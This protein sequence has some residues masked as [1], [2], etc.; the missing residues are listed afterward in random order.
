M[1]KAAK[2]TPK[3]KT[4]PKEKQEEQGYTPDDVA[5]AER[6]LHAVTEALPQI[7]NILKTT[8]EWS[9]DLKTK[10]PLLRT[11]Y[12]YRDAVDPETFKQF[13]TL[14]D[15]LRMAV[16]GVDCDCDPAIRFD[17]LDRSREEDFL[18]ACRVPRVGDDASIAKRFQQLELARINLKC[19]QST[20]ERMEKN[21]EADLKEII[22]KDDRRQKAKDCETCKG[23]GWIETD[24][25]TWHALDYGEKCRTAD[26]GCDF[27]AKPDNKYY[28]TFRLFCECQNESDEEASEDDD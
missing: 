4:K 20:V 18:P 12:S 19:I 3:V 10:P 2:K 1:S 11:S 16:F 21:F 7:D 27:R 23:K 26:I 25:A 22:K 8:D 28:K 9:D 17:L 15:F 24:A 13:S 5:R 14:I 6:L